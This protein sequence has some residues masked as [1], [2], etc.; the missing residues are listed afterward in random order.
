MALT[1]LTHPRSGAVLVVTSLILALALVAPALADNAASGPLSSGWHLVGVPTDAALPLAECQ[2]RESS[3]GQILSLPDAGAA[4]W[5]GLP[6]YFYQDGGYRT[7]GADPWDDADTVPPWAGLWCY[8]IRPGV[9]LVFSG[10]RLSAGYG[11]AVALD[12]PLYYVNWMPPIPPGGPTPPTAYMTLTVFNWT[13]LP[14]DLWFCDCQRYDFEIYDWTG[15]LM[16]RWSTGQGFCDA[17]GH[18]QL[19]RGQ[20]VY[21]ASTPL[22]TATGA[23]YPAGLYKLVAYLTTGCAPTTCPPGSTTCLLPF[24]KARGEITFEV[25]Y[26]Y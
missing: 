5:I 21:T 15:K 11:V 20:K 16:W 26:I 6:L 10:T 23:P 12:R 9:E 25:K 4:A 18:E 19:V 13:S 14:V 8:V 7:C 1:W 22:R 17:L 2:A 3:T 24:H